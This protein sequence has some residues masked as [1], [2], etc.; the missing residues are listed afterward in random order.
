[1]FQLK[2]DPLTGK[3][4]WILIEDDEGADNGKNQTNPKA[5]LSTTSYLDMLNDSRRN[6]AFNRAIQKTVT[7]PCHV[8]DIGAGTGLLSMMVA[9]A[10]G[11]S[12]SNGNSTPSRM[13]TACESYL[14]MV[15]L[16]RKVLK[17]NCLDSKVRIINKRS[18]ELE[19]GLDIPS[20][21]DI[22]EGSTL[23]CIALACYLWLNGIAMQVSEILDSELLGEGLIPTLQ[24]AHDKLLVDKPQTVPYKATTY[25]QLVECSYLWEMHDLL[26]R[27]TE[28]SDGIFLVPSGTADLLGVKQKQLAMHCDAINEEIKLLSE[29]FKVF[30]FDFWRRPESFRETELQINATNDGTVH[31]IIS[32]WLLQLDSEGTI[33][34]STAPNWLDLGSSKEE[35][36]LSPPGSRCWCDHWKQSVSFTLSSGLHVFKD[37]EVRLHAVHNETSISYEFKSSDEKKEVAHF[38]PCIQDNQIALTPERIALYGTRSWRSLMLKAVEK[39]LHQIVDPLCLVADDS[40][41]LTIAVAS[42]S[43]NAHVIPLFPGLGKKGLKYLRRVSAANGYTMDRVHTLKDLHLT[44]QD[45]RMINLLIAEPFYYGNDSVLPWQNLRRERT[46]LDSSLS[47]D[48]RIMPCRGLLK[49][50]AM[51]LPDLWQSR[52]SLQAVEGFDHTMVNTTLGACGDLPFAEDG[53]FLPVFYWQ[54]GESKVLSETATILEFD[55]SKPMSSC[56]KKTRVQFTEVG[57]CHGFVLWIDWILNEEDHIILSTGPDKRHWKQAVKLW[58]KPAEIRPGNLSSTEVEAFFDP[59][60][61]ELIL[62]HEFLT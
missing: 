10:M 30:D 41:F 51:Y 14:P 20:R 47:K 21:A 56:T 18:D 54:C 11:F 59:S 37:Q 9:R 34:Y 1:M 58:K 16:M 25:G 57:E 44:Q 4:E 61:G 28:A 31:A 5:L 33:F 46:L 13:V 27:E 12:D 15:K 60:N 3:S 62:K 36:K 26:S 40:I 8:L 38:D 39:A 23:N 43:K 35:L 7:K 48:V 55:F 19:V 29:P 52:R 49:A 45:S 6:S 53:P 22:L 17:A 50:C 2:T 42:V 24:H 32:W